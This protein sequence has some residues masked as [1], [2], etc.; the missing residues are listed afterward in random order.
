M[1]AGQRVCMFALPAPIRL[2]ACGACDGCDPFKRQVFACNELVRQEHTIHQGLLKRTALC[3]LKFGEY[4]KA[5]GLFMS[6]WERRP[7]DHVSML[8][9]MSYMMKCT[10]GAKRPDWALW[11]YDQYVRPPLFC[12]AGREAG[13][14][15]GQWSS[16]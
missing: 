6:E 10:L 13:A 11:M 4:G 1:H 7:N 3:G 15:G 9:I 12:G 2:I 14:R 5:V 8:P 16:S